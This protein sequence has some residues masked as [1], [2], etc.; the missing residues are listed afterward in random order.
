MLIYSRFGPA[1]L[2]MR[3]HDDAGT[4]KAKK[5]AS[6][7]REMLMT[8]SGKGEGKAKSAAT[9]TKHPSRQREAGQCLR[10]GPRR[11]AFRSVAIRWP[12]AA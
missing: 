10:A 4:R 3:R 5:A 1:A 7:R 11:Q 8:I 2:R 6:A 9:K 12:C